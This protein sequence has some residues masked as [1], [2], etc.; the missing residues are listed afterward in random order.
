M[1]LQYFLL[2]YSFFVYSCSD[3]EKNDEMFG[4]FG[5]NLYFCINDV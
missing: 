3:N 4:K 1:F 2:K 5:K